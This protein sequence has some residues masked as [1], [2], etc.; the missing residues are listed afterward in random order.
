MEVFPSNACPRQCPV[1]WPGIRSLR[2]L[3]K[4]GWGVDAWTVTHAY[5]RGVA[6]CRA[7]L[8]TEW[9]GSARPVV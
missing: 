2:L 1:S 9:P 7:L 8:P 5:G 6:T 4:G 3:V